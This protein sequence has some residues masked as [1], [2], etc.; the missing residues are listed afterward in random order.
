MRRTERK[1]PMRKRVHRKRTERKRTMSRKPMRKKTTS[2]RRSP[3]MNRRTNK[4]KYSYKFNWD[5]FKLKPLPKSKSTTK[6]KSRAKSDVDRYAESKVAKFQGHLITDVPIDDDYHLGTFAS[7]RNFYEYYS[8]RLNF[9]R[10]FNKIIKKLPKKI[11]YFPS[12][13]LIKELKSKFDANQIRLDLKF[14]KDY[15]DNKNLSKLGSETAVEIL[16]MMNNFIGLTK[17]I[18][19]GMKQN[20]RYIC[21]HLGLR[22]EQGGHANIVLYDTKNKVVELFEP[23]GGHDKTNIDD[24]YKDVNH[25]LKKYIEYMFPKYKFIEPKA[26]MPG[27]LQGAIDN[28]SGSCLSICMMYLHY[29]LLN[30]NI[31][32]NIIV[33]RIKEKG[34]IFLN[35]YMK[36]IE[37][38]IK[39]KKNKHKSKSI[40]TV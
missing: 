36:Y 37:N 38:T 11:L 7:K 14:I 35:K 39:N 30:P 3:R 18:K 2:K 32:S 16:P 17:E 15:K 26:Y 6:Q 29:K 24:H 19:K 34:M 25:I 20:Y 12:L 33:K 13:P 40:K 28:Y 27:V 10:F 5:D 9:K 4:S 31:P 21:I 23:H 1:K 8:N 22:L